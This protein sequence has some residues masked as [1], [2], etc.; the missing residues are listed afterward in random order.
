MIAHLFYL[1][2]NQNI[3]SVHHDG[4]NQKAV[5]YSLWGDTKRIIM[6]ADDFHT[7]YQRIPTSFNVF[8]GET[9]ENT[10]VVHLNSEHLTTLA[11]LWQAS[12]TILSNNVVG[13]VNS[14]SQEWT[15][16]KGVNIGSF[17]FT[18]HQC[19]GLTVS[20]DMYGEDYSYESDTIFDF[21]VPKL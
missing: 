14:V 11:E 2:F 13:N 15:D 4:F 18:I 5:T 1:P 6:N 10:A 12:R 21:G 8:S 3:L 19:G 17:T 7:S 9:G 20:A 16:D